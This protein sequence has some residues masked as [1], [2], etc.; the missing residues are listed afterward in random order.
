MPPRIEWST[1][2]VIT[3]YGLT[4]NLIP[5]PSEKAFHYRYIPRGSG[6]NETRS[7]WIRLD[8][9]ICRLLSGQKVAFR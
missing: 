4:H 5:T 8:S 3:F 7:S 1:Y 2:A 6:A 9:N